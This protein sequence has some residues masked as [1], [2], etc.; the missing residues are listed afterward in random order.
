MEYEPFENI[1]YCLESI[2]FFGVGTTVNLDTSG[3]EKVIQHCDN[4]D[5]MFNDMEKHD[6]LM[7]EHTSMNKSNEHFTTSIEE[8]DQIKS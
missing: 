2:V 5:F 6:R 7:N 3:E 1:S 8:N 4:V